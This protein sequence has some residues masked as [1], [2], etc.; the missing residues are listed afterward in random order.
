M[1]LFWQDEDTFL[2]KNQFCLPKRFEARGSLS[3][4]NLFVARFATSDSCSHDK[5][6]HTQRLNFVSNCSEAWTPAAVGSRSDW[7]RSILECREYIA[8]STSFKSTFSCARAGVCVCVCAVHTLIHFLMQI[9]LNLAC[10]NISSFSR[11]LLI[12]LKC[13]NIFQGSYTEVWKIMY[14]WI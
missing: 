6:S 2:F 5:C 11:F 12:C 9:F 7:L 8:S 10:P 1:F 14:P 13:V 3:R 4:C